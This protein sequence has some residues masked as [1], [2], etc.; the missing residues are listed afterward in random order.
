VLAGALLMLASALLVLAGVLLVLA[1]RLLVLAKIQ[2]TNSYWITIPNVT[3]HMSN[4]SRDV[5]LLEKLKPCGMPISGK[6]LDKTPESINRS[7]S[8]KK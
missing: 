4:K 5:M 1:N 6:E 7:P 8:N 2:N 3:K